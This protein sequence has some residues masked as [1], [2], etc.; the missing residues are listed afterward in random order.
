MP[1]TALRASAPC[2]AA[3][4]AWRC[5]SANTLRALGVAADLLAVPAPATPEAY[6]RTLYSSLR[7]LDAG[8]CARIVVE[9]P[10]PGAAWRGITDRLRRASC[11]DTRD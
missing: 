3:G 2:S 10:P 8:G 9:T 1:T 6:A 11:A 4:N 7:E 5:S